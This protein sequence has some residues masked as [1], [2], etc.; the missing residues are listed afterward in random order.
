LATAEPDRVARTGLLSSLPSSS[1]PFAYRVGRR[2]SEEARRRVQAYSSIAWRA[3]T[4]ASK[5]DRVTL[6]GVVQIALTEKIV[7]I[8]LWLLIVT[9]QKSGAEADAPQIELVTLM[10]GSIGGVKLPPPVTTIPAGQKA[11]WVACSPAGSV[12]GSE[13]T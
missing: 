9:D 6:V 10:A 13:E 12:I 3:L 11:T 8:A 5:V 4:A 2:D 7:S 1:F